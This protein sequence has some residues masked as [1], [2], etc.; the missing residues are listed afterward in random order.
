PEAVHPR[1]VRLGALSDGGLPLT[2]V[3]AGPV[4]R[5]RLAVLRTDSDVRVEA[6]GTG[7]VGDLAPGQRVGARWDRAVPLPTAERE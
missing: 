5:E 3:A 4:G 2:V 1:D 7:E 6:R